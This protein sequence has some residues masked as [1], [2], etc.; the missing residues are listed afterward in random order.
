MFKEA[1]EKGLLEV[2]DNEDGSKNFVVKQFD[3]VIDDQGK[4]KIIDKDPQTFLGITR[5]TAQRQKDEWEFVL[6]KFN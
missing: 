5:E 2:V 1:S 6:S 4:K 3:V